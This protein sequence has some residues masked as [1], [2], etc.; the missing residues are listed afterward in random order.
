[1]ASELMLAPELLERWGVRWAL[2]A[3]HPYVG[4]G[5]KRVNY[6]RLRR[7][8]K[9]ENGVLELP[10]PRAPGFFTDFYEA[11]STDAAAWRA[12]EANPLEARLQLSPEIG[13]V[14]GLPTRRDSASIANPVRELA[15]RLVERRN[16]ALSFTLEAPR[17]G[18]F[19]INEAYFPGWLAWVD[20]SPTP[21]YRV[22]GWI[23]GLPISQGSHRIEIRYRPTGWLIL[24]SVASL[25]W[26]ALGALAARACFLIYGRRHRRTAF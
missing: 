19:V 1:M 7:A 6:S 5:H 20:G 4:S 8:I 3:D 22:D 21:L 15:A 9:R 18:W 2:P 12:L 14:K 26:L 13:Q 10:N 11:R 25:L 24:A 23:R 16:N 17:A